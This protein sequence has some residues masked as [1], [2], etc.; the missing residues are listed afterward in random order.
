MYK[1]QENVENIHDCIIISNYIVQI[2]F[3]IIYYV[4]CVVL[5]LFD[6]EFIF[7]G[8]YF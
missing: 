5:L 6:S 7:L 8:W 2:L 4:L 1:Y 3:E